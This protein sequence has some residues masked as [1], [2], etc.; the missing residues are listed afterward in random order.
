MLVDSA[1]RGAAIPSTSRNETK[2]ATVTPIP[3]FL[4][5]RCDP[6]SSSFQVP[7]VERFKDHNNVWWRW[8]RWR[9]RAGHK[10][11]RWILLECD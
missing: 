10:N 4:C 1:Q 8:E 6:P 7:K 3:P 5:M 9:C 2:V 11:E